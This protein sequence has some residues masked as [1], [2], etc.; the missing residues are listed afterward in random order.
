MKA[1]KTLTLTLALLVIAALP[2]AA[3][4]ASDMWFHVKIVDSGSDNANVTV[5]LPISIVEAAFPLIPEE[6]MEGGKIRIEDAD[7]DAQKLRDLWYEVQ[8]TPDMT[9][10]T[11]RS[12]DA[13]IE[14]FKDGD[15]LVARTIEGAG[16]ANVNARL[17]LPVIDALLSGE[18]NT[19]DVRAALQAL[20]DYGQG[21]LVTVTDDDASIRVWID[22][23]PEAE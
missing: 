20:V 5:N 1:H 3:Q 21:E 14:V 18:G 23:N 6:A 22:S 10:V 16:G 4:S 9:F 8:N 19:L 17:P 7:F 11:V 12:D 2:A 13:N 15:Y